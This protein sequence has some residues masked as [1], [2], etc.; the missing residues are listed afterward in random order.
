MNVKDRH[1]IRV[2]AVDDHPIFR[3]GLAA[4]LNNDDALE[5]IAEAD[6]GEEAIALY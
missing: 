5:L 6:T 4:I 3:Q 2:M 1:R